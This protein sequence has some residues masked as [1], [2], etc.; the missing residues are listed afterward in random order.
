VLVVVVVLV[1]VVVV[2]LAVVV[3]AASVSAEAV[4]EGAVLAVD[5]V[6][7]PIGGVDTGPSASDVGA[8]EL[9]VSP[10]PCFGPLKNGPTMIDNSTSPMSP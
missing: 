7:A 5:A 4:E 1:A 10:S 8:C 2:V 9:S 6:S 3:V